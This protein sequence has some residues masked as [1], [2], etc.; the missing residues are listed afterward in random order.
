MI[1]SLVLACALVM[2][3]GGDIRAQDKKIVSAAF[4]IA[5]I[6]YATA[7]GIPARFVSDGR[8]TT[9]VRLEESPSS[10]WDPSWGPYPQFVSDALYM[11]G[12]SEAE[13]LGEGRMRVS[14]GPRKVLVDTL[15]R[16]QTELSKRGLELRLH[17]L[18]RDLN[19]NGNVHGDTN[20]DHMIGL[21][22]DGAVIVKVCTASASC[23]DRERLSHTPFEVQL[24]IITAATA[25]GAQQINMYGRFNTARGQLIHIGVSPFRNGGPGE[26]LGPVPA[27]GTRRIGYASAQKNAIGSLSPA[28]KSYRGFD[29]T[30]MDDAFQRL[31]HNPPPPGYQMLYEAIRARNLDW[32]EDLID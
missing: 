5:G 9:I 13:Y 19:A 22:A 6:E 25:A 8:R 28:A 26:M 24:R 30:E 18:S 29:G 4:E 2:S 17:M 27:D 11:L 12:D 14:Y 10:R 23:A 7:R 1:R 31:L 15:Q 21:A 32:L 3:S 16:F 20:S